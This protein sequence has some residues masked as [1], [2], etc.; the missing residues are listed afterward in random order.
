MR[1]W[2]QIIDYIKTEKTVDALV[3]KKLVRLPMLPTQAPLYPFY[4]VDFLIDGCKRKFRMDEATYSQIPEKAK[5]RLTYQSSRMIRF[6][7]EGFCV[8]VKADRWYQ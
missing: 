8:V 2:E 5:G 4:E 7:G 3:V 6:Q 1:A